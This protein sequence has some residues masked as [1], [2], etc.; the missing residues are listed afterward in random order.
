MKKI[1][2][3]LFS[4]I[5]IFSAC[6]NDLVIP[7]DTEEDSTENPEAPEEPENPEEFVPVASEWILGGN[8]SV[9]PT[10]G[11]VFILRK[12][13]AGKTF[14]IIKWSPAAF[15]N[16]DENIIYAIQMALEKEDGSD[17]IFA[18]VASTTATEYA[19]TTGELGSCILKGGGIKKRTNDMMMRISAYIVESPE[20]PL[21]SEEHKFT[22]TIYPDALDELYFVSAG[23]R[24][25]EEVEY[26]VSASCNSVYEGFAC[27]PYGVDGI[28]LMEEI[29]PNVKWGIASSTAQGAALTLIKETDGG[30][31]IKPGA[32]GTGNIETSFVANGYYRVY[33]NVA[34][35]ATDKRIQIYRFYD[36]FFVCGQRNVNYKE[37]GMNMSGQHP[38]IPAWNLSGTGNP[39]NYVVWG[40]GV[41]LTYYPQ[42]RVWKTDVVYVPKYQTGAGVPPQAE[43]TSPFEFKLRANWCCSFNIQTGTA[44]ST[45]Q[46]GVNLGGKQTDMPIATGIQ[47]GL[48][49][50][51]GTGPGNPSNGNIKVN[52]EKAGYYYWKIYLNEYPCRYELIPA[53][54]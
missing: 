15:G 14:D 6:G 40:T 4:A 34:P 33:V 9:F 24:N 28:W 27:I 48:L 25:A 1:R 41:K 51:P 47:Q 42:E 26:V 10:Q 46:A 3:I 8:S 45:W 12:E 30:Q 20:L 49:G 52:I 50:G 17:P 44:T 13:N 5:L 19:F 21:L 16:K 11:S 23:I 36:D 2:F 18:T 37:W 22:A 53:E 7:E 31:P 39:A 38:K 32:F 29:N 43:N 35:E 54:K